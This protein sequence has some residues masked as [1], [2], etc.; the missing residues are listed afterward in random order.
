VTVA[1]GATRR[2]CSR[3]QKPS[4]CVLESILYFFRCWN[5]YLNYWQY[6]IFLLHCELVIVGVI[7][8]SKKVMC[9]FVLFFLCMFS[10]KKN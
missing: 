5:V 8:N 6:F 1:R 2:Y 7:K 9:A 3:A 4:S 10:N